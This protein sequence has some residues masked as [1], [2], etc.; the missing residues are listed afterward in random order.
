MIRNNVKNAILKNE[1]KNII[2]KFTKNKNEDKIKNK[3]NKLCE[4]T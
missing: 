2:F 4:I 3:F 1:L